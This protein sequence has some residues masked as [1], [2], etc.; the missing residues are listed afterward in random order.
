VPFVFVFSPS[1]LLVAK[2]FTWFDFWVTFIGCVIGITALAAALSKFFLVEMQRWEQALCIAAAL[3]LIAPGLTPTLI[4]AA[5]LL[6]LLL[7]Q[8]AAW[9]LKGSA[10]PAGAG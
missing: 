7:R 2:G 3:L 5:L 1:L 4:G 8:L 10:V 9:K 6:P